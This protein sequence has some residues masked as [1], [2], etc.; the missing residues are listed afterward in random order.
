MYYIM[1][2]IDF[3]DIQFVIQS[4]SKSHDQ[5]RQHAATVLQEI[6]NMN[7]KMAGLMGAAAGGAAGHVA[8]KKM[9]EKS[10]D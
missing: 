10:E 1:Y 7:C 2:S 3:K 8:E 5:W 4:S 9:K 6:C